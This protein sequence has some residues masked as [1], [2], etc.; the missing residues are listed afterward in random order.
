MSAIET[1]ARTLA[2][3]AQMVGGEKDLAARL[4]V[5]LLLLTEWIAGRKAPPQRIF[6]D[7]VDIVME[8]SLQQ[9]TA[10]PEDGAPTR[11]LKSSGG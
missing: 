10:A 7:A 3:A 4:G 1:Y 9:E 5:P 8:H 11:P 6:L 2:R